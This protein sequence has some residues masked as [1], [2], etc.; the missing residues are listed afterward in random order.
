[1]SRL[2]VVRN[3]GTSAFEISAV[4]LAG[5]HASAFAIQSGDSPSTLAPGETRE[6]SVRFAPSALGAAS[7]MLRIASD[8]ADAPVLD[9]ALAGNGV[10]PEL[11]VD[12]ASHDFGD[13]RLGAAASRLFVIRN[14]G[15]S[16][17]DVSAVGLAGT[18]PAAFAIESGG[19]P[20][21]LAPGETR[22]VSVRFAPSALGGANAV[23]HITSDDADETV[24]DAALSGTGVAPDVAVDPASHDFG[25]MRLGAGASRIFVVRNEGT[26]ALAVSA[27]DLTGAHA[28]AFAIESGGTPSVLGPG[29]TREISVRFAPTALGAASALLRIASDDA[30]EAVLDVALTGNG[31]QQD[32]A[33]SPLAL[34]FGSVLRGAAA[35][36]SVEIRN[37]GT[38]YLVLGSTEIVGPG[39]SAY[40]IE[41]GAGPVTIAPGGSWP[42]ALRFA[43]S[44]LG[45]A[46]AV[47]RV[48]SDD[49]DEGVV[50]V[51]LTGTGFDY[52]PDAIVL[53]ETR[54]GGSGGGASVATASNMA[55]VPGDL[56]L[57]TVSTKSYQRVVG[58]SGLGLSWTPVLSQCAT[59][60]RTGVDVWMA[61]GTPSAAG[62]VTAALQGAP[63]SAVIVVSRYAGVDEASPIGALASRNGNGVSGSCGSGPEG[64]SYAFDLATSAARAVVF[65][66]AAMRQKQHTAGTGWL[67]R[68]EL[69]QG[70]GGNATSVATMDRL[71]ATPGPVS[72]NG[73]FDGSTEWAAVA[74]ELR[75]ATIVVTSAT[76]Q[77]PTSGE[78]PSSI[79]GLAGPGADGAAATGALLAFGLSPARPNPFRGE[80]S[81][82]YALPAPD[83]VEIVVYDAAGRLVRRL[84]NGPQAAG[85]HEVRWNG[86]NDSGVSVGSGVYFLRVRAGSQALLRKLV[87][88]N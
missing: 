84:G 9:V 82:E 73:T 72:V 17:L 23:L 62:R 65:A 67:E 4:G 59:D 55:A 21:A 25:D 75:P 29:E 61:Q 53:A 35:L 5:V 31:V 57:A 48:G 42:V 41:S 83:V 47:L 20:G 26:S 71:V 13:V 15:T 80:T 52:G 43:P 18:H 19:E 22:E 27:I 56:Y 51:A 49:P 24:V 33:V 37:E 50:D 87:L 32:V 1:V 86:R 45:S 69:H 66:A 3:Q 44:S 38:A 14:E 40:S 54:T 36:S 74:V 70:A 77:M 81:L 64:S 10:A 7:A 79:R 60:A 2:F 8:D 16:A 76:Q 34:D 68:A 39:A 12:P 88:I 58:V 46:T 85:V 78:D 28:S 63:S 30:D 6:I 11:A